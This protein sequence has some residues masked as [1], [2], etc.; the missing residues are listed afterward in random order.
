MLRLA[1]ITGILAVLVAVLAVSS[2]AATPAFP[3]RIDLP[4]GWPPEGIGIGNGTTFYVSNTANGGIYSGDLRTGVGSVLVP[5]VAGRS[6]FGIFPDKYGRL[7][8][9]GGGTGDGYVYDAKTG[10]LLKQYTLTTDL[11]TRI[12]DV[13]ATDDAAYFTCGSVTCA[14]P[15]VLFKVPIGPNGAL[16]D[17]VETVPLPATLTG[18]NG[19]EATP[20]GKTLL[21]G[22]TNTGKLFK[23][24]TTTGNVTE[25]TLNESLGRTDG[26]ILDGDVLYSNN[27]SP[28]GYIAAV[29]LAPDF[30]SG[31]V[32]AHLNSA[33]NPLHN[34]ATADDYGHLIYTIARNAAGPGVTP[35]YWLTRIEKIGPTCLTG[36]LTGTLVVASAD[37][38]CLGPGARQTGPVTVAP[39]GSLVLDGA[40]VTGPV[41]VS[42]AVSVRVCGSTVT[43]PFS[44]KE[45]SGLVLV[46]GDAATDVCAGNTFT[47]PVSITDNTAGVEFNGN[48]V[49]GPLTIT[50]TSGTLPAPDTGPVHASGN[51]VLGPT[52]IQP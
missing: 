21:I 2:S 12:N 50:G 38:V 26:L 39:G 16:E 51:A 11:P 14:G 36:A 25:V 22:Q 18:T 52:T 17:T 33:A 46:G 49:I 6:S 7:W 29:Q 37:A 3:P 41:R 1:R 47:G 4:A 24:D 20:D 10:A 32:I 44:V 48:R 19:I 15:T 31:T 30:N 13:Y 43:G 5:G 45:S 28:D 34:P 40:I 23:L 42:E 9:A 27:N 35:V 8:V